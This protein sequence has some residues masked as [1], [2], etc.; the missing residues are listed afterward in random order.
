[1]GLSLCALPGTVFAA[2]VDEAFEAARQDVEQGR[3]D[4]IEARFAEVPGVEAR[5]TLLA[6][7][8]EIRAG[9]YP[10]ALN[11]LEGIRGSRELSSSQV[12][13]AELYRGVALYHLERYSESRTS[14]EAADG[15]TVE[16]AQLQ[17][18]LGLIHLRD[19]DNERAAPELEDAA[20][21]APELTEPVASYYAGLAWQ[22]ASERGRA[23]DAYQRVIDLDGD[24]AWGKEAKKLIEATELYP[25]FVRGRVGIEW[26]DNALLRGNVQELNN[27][28]NSLSSDGERSWRGVW[29]IDGGVQLFESDDAD[30][31]A[32]VT[33]GYSGNAHFS[34]S[35][36]DVQYPT[37]GAY[38]S[39][40]LGFQT[41]AQARYRFGH[42]WVD[43]DP[44]LRSQVG[45]LSLSHTW[46]RAGTSLI[47]VDVLSN[48]LFFNPFEVPDNGTPGPN[49]GAICA[50]APGAGFIG[51]SPNGL[52]ERRE[53]D[54]QGI[55]YGA[56]LSHRFL[57]PL[58]NAMEEVLEAVEVGGGYRFGYYDSDGNEWEHFSHVL[59]ADVAVELPLDFSVAVRTTYEHRDFA[60]PSTF[61]DNEIAGQEYFLSS[62]DR[63]EHQ[64]S[65]EGEVEKDLTQN[66]SVSARYLFSDSESNRAAYDYTRHIVGGYLKFRFD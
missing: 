29:E 34:L 9:R 43:N 17:L 32:G 62:V 66:L 56:A 51:C 36:V 19:G 12:G 2:S 4:Q 24:G 55:G 37:V 26:D 33:A 23:R 40:R 11:R 45:E 20:R 44:Y 50:P 61:A 47:L 42:A 65:F 35:E 30:W 49:P 14:L 39:R 16:E 13:D 58:P 57:V 27:P 21:M 25:Y 3:C 28:V 10:E 22:G 38:L 8:C 15:L 63:E 64:I 52:N 59:S 60:N 6:A 41:F 31:S 5:A 54:R 7:Q 1:M 48:K 18:Y 46:T 53:R